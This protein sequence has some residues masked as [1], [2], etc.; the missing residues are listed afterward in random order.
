MIEFKKPKIECDFICFVKLFIVIVCYN[1][2]QEHEKK[3]K[4]SFVG[5]CMR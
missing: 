4:G 2:E 3:T 5:K 1:V